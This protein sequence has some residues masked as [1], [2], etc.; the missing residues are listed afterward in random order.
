[1]DVLIE[2]QTMFTQ[3]LFVSFNLQ[4]KNSRL[5]DN[6]Q[7][8]KH[9][10]GWNSCSQQSFIFSVVVTLIRKRKNSISNLKRVALEKAALPRN[11]INR[12]LKSCSES[13]IVT[14]SN[15]L[16]FKLANQRK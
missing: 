5:K 7:I 13:E 4:K 15:L 16:S 3:I 11:F 14:K 9:S 2:E 10:R 12:N 6:V 1:M 8:R